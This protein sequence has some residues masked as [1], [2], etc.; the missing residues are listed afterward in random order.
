MQPSAVKAAIRSKKKGWL[1]PNQGA[2]GWIAGPFVC[3]WL[4]A[5]DRY[6]PMLLGRI[7]RDGMS[8]KVT[9]RAG[10]DLNGLILFTLLIPLLVW[11]A[12]ELVLQGEWSSRGFV[13]LTVVIFLS[14]FFFW[15]SHKDRK[16]AEP[17]VRFLRDTI[18]ASGN[19]LQSRFAGLPVST[20]ITMNFSDERRDA[21]ATSD[22]IFDALQAAMP[23]DYL[24]LSK[25]DEEYIQALAQDGGFVIEKR[26]GSRMQHFKAIQA[27]K[28]ID[29][30]GRSLFTFE[31]ALAALMAYAS[32][33][34]EPQRMRWERM[35]LP[36]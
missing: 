11:L 36:E 6:G 23:E 17:L 5:F 34:L 2:R 10:S 22:G 20:S 4:S 7:S 13:I 35:D 15:V 30:E 29:K 25:S 3:L 27:G 9:G 1:N 31:E 19:S 12:F 18:T 33:S 28:E 16:Q 14:P 21:P 8:T 24:I 26:E 32:E